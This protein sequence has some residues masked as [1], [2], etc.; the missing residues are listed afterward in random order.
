MPSQCDRNVLPE[1]DTENPAADPNAFATMTLM[2]SGTNLP[3]VFINAF[4]QQITDEDR[5]AADFG[6]IH[7]TQLDSTG[8]PVSSELNRIPADLT[9]S[10]FTRSFLVEIEASNAGLLKYLK[11]N[12]D[13]EPKVP[14]T[15]TFD[16]TTRADNTKEC[17]INNFVSPS[18]GTEYDISEVKEEDERLLGMPTEDDWEMHGPYVDKTLMR[19]VLA[20]HLSGQMSRRYAPKTRWGEVLLSDHGSDFPGVYQYRGVYVFTEKIEVDTLLR[21]TSCLL[22]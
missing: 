4:G 5:E 13:F 22:N 15:I 2:D 3:L 21:I 20:H 9:T 1:R 18:E 11:C 17:H 12:Y 8:D 14:V 6:I 16:A 7:N 19:N 10:S